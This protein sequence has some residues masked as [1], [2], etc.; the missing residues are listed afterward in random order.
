M[1]KLDY[2]N[3]IISQVMKKSM[4]SSFYV[5]CYMR[6][7]IYENIQQIKIYVLNQVVFAEIK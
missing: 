3:L 1:K 5:D 6:D 7:L 2:H 4:N